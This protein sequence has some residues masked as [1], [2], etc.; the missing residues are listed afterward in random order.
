MPYNSPP[1]SSGRGRDVRAERGTETD[2]EGAYNNIFS[3]GG[4][5]YI[6][7]KRTGLIIDPPDGKRPP[8]TEEGRKLMAARRPEPLRHAGRER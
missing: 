3:T 7:S 8:I 4:G 5:R 6:R 1:R 2:V